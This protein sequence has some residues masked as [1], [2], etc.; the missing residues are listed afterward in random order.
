MAANGH[1]HGGRSILVLYRV[2]NAE[3]D[4]SDP[5]FNCFQMPYVKSPTLNSVKQH[6]AAAHSLSH[7]GPEGFHWRVLVEDRPGASGEKSFSWWDIQ[8]G[9]AKLPVKETSQYELRKLLFPPKPSVGT[10]AAKGAFKMMG[11]MASAVTGEDM[12][13]SQ[14]PPVAVMTFKLL[15]LVKIHEDFEKKHGVQPRTTTPRPR[16]APA[17]RPAAKPRPQGR[18]QQSRAPQPRA[19]PASQRAPAASLMDFG[20]AP[21]SA[22]ANLP[23]NETRAQR[24]KREHEAKI[25]TTNRVWDDVDQRW[26]EVK[27]GQPLPG[28]KSTAAA[29]PEKPKSKVVGIKLDG[30]S[31]AGKSANVQQAVNKRVNDMKEQQAKALQEVRER[32][33]KKKQAEE[34]EDVARK[35]LEPKIKAW[36]EEHG[37]KKQLRALLANLHTILWPGAK[38]KQLSIGDILND[39]KVKR[40]Y[41]KATLVVHPDKTHH[42]PADQRFLAKRIFDALSQA[43]TEFDNGTR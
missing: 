14:G 1:H 20:A 41:H 26:V 3:A 32:E 33:A 28:A 21:S 27:P 4:S 6:C 25:K 16:A 29:I 43:K 2:V 17:P 22:P 5:L 42:L 13:E 40:A 18:P 39:S 30:S 12:G 10:T 24:L 23:K 38:W 37:K 31:A 35:A 34:E 7:L 8:D 36:S 11:K 15:D 9:N 19:Q